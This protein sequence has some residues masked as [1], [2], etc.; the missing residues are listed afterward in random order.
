MKSVNPHDKYFKYVFSKT[1]NAA[2][3]ISNSLKKEIVK[4]LDFN[5]LKLE[6]SEYVNKRLKTSFSDLVFS[7]KMGKA[8]V[9]I[10]ILLE[11]KSYVP[12]H[13]HIQ[14]LEYLTN[15]WTIQKE[16]QKFLDRIIPIYIYH[17]K[18][19]WK[20]KSFKSSFSRGTELFDTITPIFDYFILDLSKFNDETIQTKF[21]E[22][23]V[24]TRLLLLKNYFNS[25]ILN[26]RL[27]VTSNNYF[28][29]KIP[30]TLRNLLFLKHSNRTT[31]FLF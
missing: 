6:S 16:K 27:K 5:S 24:K 8:K 9:T 29:E 28:M 17:G 30:S 19:K 26:K 12:K 22:V 21:R 3:L 18:D 7:C 11:H 23:F 20:N 2:D 31:M 25:L 10:S 4:E 1:E 15:I 13:P 14:I